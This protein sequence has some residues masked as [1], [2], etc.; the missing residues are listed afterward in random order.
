[1][2]TRYQYFEF[3]V[4]RDIRSIRERDNGCCSWILF[5]FQ[6]T[7]FNLLVLVALHFTAFY[8]ETCT[9]TIFH[10]SQNK[11]C[12]LKLDR[13]VQFFTR[14]RLLLQMIEDSGSVGRESPRNT[15][16][17][18]P[19]TPN[20]HPELLPLRLINLSRYFGRIFFRRNNTSRYS[21]LID[22]VNLFSSF[23]IK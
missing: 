11:F 8:Y 6:L 13:R 9:V 5:S 10:G 4:A 17:H 12:L 3:S 2:R 15:P 1:M 21:L 14:E 20:P 7:A 16:S 19:L 22:L 23:I 18:H